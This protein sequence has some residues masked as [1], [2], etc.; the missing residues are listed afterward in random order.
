MMGRRA[1]GCGLQDKGG[2]TAGVRRREVQW[3]AGGCSSGNKVSVGW[4]ATKQK[5]DG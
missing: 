4:V 5:D 3:R 2:A 1:T